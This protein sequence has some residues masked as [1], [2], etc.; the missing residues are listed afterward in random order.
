MTPEQK[1]R[2]LILMQEQ[3]RAKAQPDPQ[4]QVDRHGAPVISKASIQERFD[5]EKNRSEFIQAQVE[6][7]TLGLIGDEAR[8]GLSALTGPESYSGALSRERAEEAQFR[9]TSPGA[10]VLADVS[11]VVVPGVAAAKKIQQVTGAGRTGAAAITGAGGG[12]TYSAAE[13]EGGKDRAADALVGAMAGALFGATAS[14]ALDGL[15]AVPNRVKNLFSR[16]EQRPSTGLL[17]A[18]KSAAYRAVDES[19]ET[20][21]SDDLTGLYLQVSDLFEAKNYVEEVDDA[22][23]AVL[24][25]I[26]RRAEK[27][28][29]TLS[30]LD[31]VR[32]SLWKRYSRAGDQPQILDAVWAID[33]L[34]A[35]RADASELMSVAR[36]ANSRFAKSQLLENAF[37][38]A[39]RQTASTGSGG[40]IL[41]KYRQAVTSILS[42]EKKSRFFTKEEI[43]L[44]DRF[45]RGDFKENVLRKLGKLSPDGNGLMLTLHV[46][47]GMAS[48]GATLPAAA[49]GSVAKRRADRAVEKG[50]ENLLD[51]VSG[52]KPANPPQIPFTPAA[53][54]I[55]AGSVPFAQDAADTSTRALRRLMRNRSQ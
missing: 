26:E 34:I 11:G 18:T 6:G 48:S 28:T 23:R 9:E 38:K 31:G 45:V 32:Q 27:P 19:G 12:A 36:A 44:M 7:A 17:K 8:A 37:T 10:S 3:A 54:A 20:F 24:R 46:V 15:T 25:T 53:G 42:D 52:Y 40:N 51:V 4:P 21:S 55:S 14:K 22:S 50:A 5:R 49:V 43:D 35:T 41:N 1:R 33:E 29:T 13:G 16:S 2:K 47:G 39:E 30:Q